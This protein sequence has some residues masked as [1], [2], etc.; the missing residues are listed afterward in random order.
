MAGLIAPGVC[1][2]TVHGT[3]GGRAIAN[4]LDYFIA[5]GGGVTRVQA[6]EQQA[7]VIISAWADEIMPNLADNYVA[8]S[9]SWVDLDSAL[10]T[11][12]SATLGVGSDFPAPGLST[13]EPH[14][15]NVAVRI[16]KGITALRGQ[17]Q[18]RMYWVGAPESITTDAA[19][20]TIQAGNQVT[21]TGNAEAFL[22]A[23]NVAPGGSPDY[24][25]ELVVLHTHREAPVPP[26]TVGE[27]VY[28][29]LSPVETMTCDATLASQRRRLRG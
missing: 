25:S 2:Y 15:G 28:D 29:G 17:R 18:G 12:G 10:G 20:N 26:A 11:V 14:P 3:Y 23:A 16:N 5:P 13:G 27:I 19:P 1:R 7:K 4:I 6:I 8:T 21:F 24:F 22:A 9:L